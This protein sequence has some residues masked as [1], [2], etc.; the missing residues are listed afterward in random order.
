MQTVLVVITISAAVA[1]LSYKA[2]RTWWVKPDKGCDKCAVKK[3]VISS[4]KQ[5]RFA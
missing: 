1:Y 2:Y 4:K 5:D 3:P